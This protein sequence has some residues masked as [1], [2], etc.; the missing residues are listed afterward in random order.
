MGWTLDDDVEVDTVYVVL[1]DVIVVA[2][3][4]LLVLLADVP[5]EDVADG[6]RELGV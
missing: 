2:P 3:V 1:V 4:K 6:R 5:I